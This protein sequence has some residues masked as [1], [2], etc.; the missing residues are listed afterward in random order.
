MTPRVNTCTWHSVDEV[1]CYAVMKDSSKK[2]A[3]NMITVI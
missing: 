2:A 1:K 3:G